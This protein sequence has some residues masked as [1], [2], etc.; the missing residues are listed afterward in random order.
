MKRTALMALMTVVGTAG[1]SGGRN[2][3]VILAS[4]HVEA[5]EVRVATKVGGFLAALQC[6]E[7]DTTDTRLALRVAQG[8]RDQAGAQVRLMRA[9]ARP[10]DVADAA[11]QVERAEADVVVAQKDLD[12]MEGLL[13]VGSGTTKGR[14]DA[15]ARRDVAAALRA[16]ANER[17]G[18]LRAGNRSEEIEAAQGRLAAAEARV[19]QIE[20]Q[21]QDA[22]IVSP[23]AG[24]VTERVAERGELLARGSVIVVVTDLASAWLTVYVAETDLGRIRIGQE[25]AVVT[26]AGQKRIGRLAYVS[27]R[28]EF[29]PKNVQTRDERV[30]L[31]Y[32]LKVTLPNDDQ[33][34]KPGM[35]AEARIT[36][37][38]G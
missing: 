32:R 33:V 17:L 31:V 34:F 25:V 21:L 10:E 2:G 23:V 19:A 16:S 24:V 13:A 28:A 15:R 35:P 7:G 30:K 37:V 3:G 9:G 12:R 20:Q 11:A 22:S 6:E 26:D 27:P 38:Q 8:E 29:T 36:P 14:D 1:C 5:T 4:G 18:K